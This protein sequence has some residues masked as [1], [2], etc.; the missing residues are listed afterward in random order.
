MSLEIR[1]G[2]VACLRLIC[3]LRAIYSCTVRHAQ[4]RDL[5]LGLA[6]AM[7]IIY[8]DWSSGVYKLAEIT[9]NRMSSPSPPARGK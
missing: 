5:G 4:L 6:I 2:Y 8:T 9:A 7:Y 1:F 3:L